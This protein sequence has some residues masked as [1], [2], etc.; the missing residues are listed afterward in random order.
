VC[1]R[2]KHQSILFLADYIIIIFIIIAERSPLFCFLPRVG[3]LLNRWIQERSAVTA[4]DVLS[5]LVLRPEYIPI[6]W[7]VVASQR[8]DEFLV[9][10]LR[11][12]R[13]GLRSV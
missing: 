1:K 10:R 8:A 11:A 5:T 3:M 13:P 7:K 9:R 12:W 4:S 6:M 2:A